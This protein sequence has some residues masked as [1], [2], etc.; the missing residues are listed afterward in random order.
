LAPAGQVRS[1]GGRGVVVIEARRRGGAAEHG[2]EPGDV[3]LE[4]GGK[5]VNSAD[6]VRSALVDARRGGKRLVM[7]RVHS[8]ATSRFLA[9]PVG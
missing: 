2:L 6:D 7:L 5:V 1:A 9:L 3:I 8:G 4:V